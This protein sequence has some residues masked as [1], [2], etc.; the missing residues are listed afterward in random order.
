MKNLKMDY[1]PQKNKKR[2]DR[3]Y[4][5]KKH[6]ERKALK[7]KYYN[8]IKIIDDSELKVLIEDAKLCQLSPMDTETVLKGQRREPNGNVLDGGDENK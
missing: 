7:F 4:R 8:K 6:H 5:D 2:A 1:F 3:R